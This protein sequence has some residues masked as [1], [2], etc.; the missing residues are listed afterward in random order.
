MKRVRMALAKVEPRQTLY[1]EVRADPNTLSA[2]Q[3]SEPPSCLPT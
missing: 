2:G 1:D 3:Q